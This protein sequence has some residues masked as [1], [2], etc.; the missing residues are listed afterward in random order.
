MLYS[1][2]TWRAIT[3]VL[4][5]ERIGLLFG[6]SASCSGMENDYDN[7]KGTFVFAG[8]LVFAR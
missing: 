6:K 5:Q 4:I 1:P 3:I 7:Q 2:W 8:S